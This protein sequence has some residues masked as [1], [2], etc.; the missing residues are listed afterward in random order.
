MKL[1]ERFV[2]VI[3][4]KEK[5]PYLDLVWDMI[6]TSY[7]PLGGIKGSGFSSKEDMFNNIPFWKIAK[8]NGKVVAVVLYKDKGG[9]KRVAAGT[10]GSVEGKDMLARIMKD[11]LTQQRSYAEVSG[12]SLKFIIKKYGAGLSKHIILPS[13]AEKIL[14]VKLE[15]PVPKDDKEVVANPELHK[16]FYI[17]DVNGIP[18]TKLMM[19][20]PGQNIK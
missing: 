1:I 11:D 2:N 7:K 4:D 18:L 9:R 3:D 19:G 16:Y 14:G 8:K 13:E 15:Y 5:E 20:T 12:P 10:D 6:Q 17:R